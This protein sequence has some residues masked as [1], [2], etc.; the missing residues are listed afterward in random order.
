VTDESQKLNQLLQAAQSCHHEKRWPE[1]IAAYRAALQF[2]PEDA[3]IHFNLGATL[4]AAGDLRGAADAYRAALR[5]RPDWPEAHAN[6]GNVLVQQGNLG[7]AAEAYRNAVAARPGYLAAHARLGDCLFDLKD[8]AGALR[9]YREARVMVERSVTAP[10]STPESKPGSNRESTTESPALLGS[11]H[12]REAATLQKLGRIMEAETAYRHALR[13]QPDHVHSYINLAK[14]ERDLARYDEAVSLLRTARDLAPGNRLVATNLLFQLSYQ[15][16]I[17]PEAV[18]AAHRAWDKQFG[19]AGRAAC[20]RHAPPA[21]DDTRGRDKPLRIGYVSPDLKHHAVSRFFE[22]LLAAHDRSRVE[23]YCY[24]EVAAP[25]AVTERLKAQADHWRTTVGKSDAEVARQI[26]EDGIDILIDLAGHTAD[27]RLQVFTYKPAP[28]HASYL[29]YCTTTGLEA[30]DYWITDA[31]VTPED[32]VERTCETIWRLPRCWLCY[33]PDPGTGS[34]AP[35]VTPR[36]TDGPVT[37]GSFNQLSKLSESVIALWSEVLKAVPD[38]RLL[39]KAQPLADE[40][41]RAEIRGRFARLGVASDRLDLRG[42][43]LD[44]LLE[45]GEVDIALDPFP[46][47]GGATTTDALWMGVPVVTLAGERMIERQGASL[48]TAVGL[49]EL[50]ATDRA[51]YVAKAVALARN[52]ERRARLRSELRERMAASELCDGR[53]LAAALEDAYREM[54]HR[55]VKR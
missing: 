36:P 18:L 21:A 50:I 7:A 34:E 30:M 28:I 51:D 17:E 25:D 13:L 14:I 53:G 6:L 29:G 3:A 52:P 20:F 11:L 39:L 10:E 40:G 45:Y 5:I 9:H 43:T 38:A 42:A 44:F 2:A 47:T 32:T 26:F 16:L 46:R 31:V 37:F 22:P 54:W 12:Y 49:E 27:N 1:A 23:V 8:F 15:T 24:A 55:Y 35:A 41:V 19:E 4:W 48:L 33:R